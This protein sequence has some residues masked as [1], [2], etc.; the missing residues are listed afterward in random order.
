M[1]SDRK[2]N[3]RT[4]SSLRRRLVG[5]GVLA[6]T[7][8]QLSSVRE[9]APPTASPA[10]Y[11]NYVFASE[12]GSGIYEISGRTIQIYQIPMTFNLR[13]A[14]LQ[15]QPPGLDFIIPITFGFFNFEPNDLLHLKVPTQIGALS[16]QP[17]VQLDYWLSNAWHLYPYARVGGTFASSARISAFIYST[18]IRSDLQFYELGGT[19][20]WR[21]E[22]LHAGAHFLSTLPD[23]AFTRL[24]N[25]AELRRTFGVAVGKRN[26]ELA[27]YGMVDIFFDAPASPASGISPRTV[28]F[29]SGLMLG[30][31]PMWQIWGITLPR[32]GIG[33]RV[34]GDLSGWRLVLGDPF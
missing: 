10:D 16:L 29:E 12:L 11:A 2:R 20:L 9:A 28:Q 22:L 24:R 8:G 6:L 13:P 25:G 21:A 23:D 27:P 5:A 15:E 7:A 34:A 14:V 19:G 1:R 31:N 3:S 30:V 18:G 17:G 33:Y 26:L 4:G 32:I